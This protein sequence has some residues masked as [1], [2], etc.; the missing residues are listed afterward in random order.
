MSAEAATSATPERPSRWNLPPWLAAW[1]MPA[2]LVA[3]LGVLLMQFQS[4]HVEIQASRTENLAAIERLSAESKADN[5]E[6]RA[7]MERINARIDETNV[8]I[9]SSSA[10]L[11]ASIQQTNERIDETNASVRETNVR[12]DGLYERLPPR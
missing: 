5:R 6:L 2:V 3:V 11:N 9:D 7:E 10:S 8:R 4:V 1:A 12:I